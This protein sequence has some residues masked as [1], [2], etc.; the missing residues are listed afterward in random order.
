VLG[1]IAAL[2]DSGREYPEP[3]VNEKLR[4]L[5]ADYALT[6]RYLIDEGFLARESRLAEGRTRVVYWRVGPKTPPAEM[7]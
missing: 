6:R 2:F 3:E 7:A 5:D 1:S 4:G